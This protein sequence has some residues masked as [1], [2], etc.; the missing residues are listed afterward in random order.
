MGAKRSLDRF[1]ARVKCQS[2]LFRMIRKTPAWRRGFGLV[3]AAGQLILIFRKGLDYTF[4]PRGMRS[5]LSGTMC[6]PDPSANSFPRKVLGISQ[7]MSLYRAGLELASFLPLGI[8]LAV[9]RFRF[10]RCELRFH[11]AIS[12]R[13][14]PIDRTRVRK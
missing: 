7:S 13:G 14:D 10:H 9:A 8:A 4:I 12:G 3:E 2:E 1:V 6:V 11:S 5:V